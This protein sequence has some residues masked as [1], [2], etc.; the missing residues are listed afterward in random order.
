MKD[1]ATV[2]EQILAHPPKSNHFV[3]YNFLVP[4]ARHFD[5]FLQTA[6]TPGSS[7]METP[8]LT[9]KKR[10]SSSSLLSTEISVFAAATEAFSHANINCS[11][12]QSL[13][14]FRPILAQA[15][16][17]KVR[18][19]GYVSVAL[20]CPYEGPNVDPGKVAEVTASLLE[21][22]V[23]EVSVADTTGMG[24]APRTRELLKR[25]SAAGIANH[26]LALHF[27]DTYGQALV[28]AV[29]GLEHGI[30]TFDSAVGGLGGCPFAKGA[31]GNVATEDLMYCLHS[32]G[33]HTGVDVQEMA[34][35]GAWISQALGREYESRAGKAI[36]ARL[37]E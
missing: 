3:S 18:A 20:G 11:I 33:V 27:H 22:G 29:V 5:L 13:E 34:E 26:D 25:L 19:R 23:D 31:T 14:R 10:N 24:T 7:L 1:S 15:K 36:L 30:R 21:M 17:K 6:A 32:L 37:K 4:T 2:L 8:P 12:A 35:I 16:A 28:N 9:S